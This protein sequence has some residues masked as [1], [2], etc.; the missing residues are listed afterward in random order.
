MAILNFLSGLITPDGDSISLVFNGGVDLTHPY[1]LSIPKPDF[2]LSFQRDFEILTAGIQEDIAEE[3]FNSDG[4]QGDYTVTTIG[5]T[6]IILNIKLSIPI[7]ETDTGIL[8]DMV[9]G[10]FTDSNSNRTPEL[11]G[12]VIT[13]NSVLEQPNLVVMRGLNALKKIKTITEGTI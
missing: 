7:Y 12:Q 4:T 9:F 6:S 11:A 8:L 2:V 1:I 13:N 10:Q 3:V 5:S